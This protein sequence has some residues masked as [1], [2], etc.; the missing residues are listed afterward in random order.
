MN[1]WIPDIRKSRQH[2]TLTSRQ[3]ALVKW[4]GLFVGW[5]L[6]TGLLSAVHLGLLIWPLMAALILY[7][8]VDI[9]RTTPPARRP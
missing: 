3:R 7:V 2:G 9:L 1:R 8:F 6:V 5:V 4:T